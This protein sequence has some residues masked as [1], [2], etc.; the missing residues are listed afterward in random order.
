MLRVA[1]SLS[2]SEPQLCGC[3]FFS[4]AGL[5]TGHSRTI[6]YPNRDRNERFKDWPS[7]GD[8]RLL[9]E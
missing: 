4:C 5:E 9:G 1:I 3:L 8:G 6:Q 2:A 7:R